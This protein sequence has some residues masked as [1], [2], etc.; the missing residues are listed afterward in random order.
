[1]QKKTSKTSKKAIA[2]D[3]LALLIISILILSTMFLFIQ[4]NKKSTEAISDAELCRNTILSKSQEYLQ[5][6]INKEIE[7]KCPTNYIKLNKKI[8]DSEINKKILDQRDECWYKMGGDSIVSG[9]TDPFKDEKI[10]CV[11]CSV[12]DF[13]PNNREIKGLG[14]DYLKLQSRYITQEQYDAALSRIQSQDKIDG[15]Q[16]YSMLFVQIRDK[17]FIDRNLAAEKSPRELSEMAGG[18]ALAVVGIKVAIAGTAVTMGTIA[19]GGT[20][21]IVGAA[22]GLYG[23]F[24]DQGEPQL[25]AMTTLVKYNKEE[26]QKLGCQELPVSVS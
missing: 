4:Q 18:A 22:I 12:F 5:I 11:V 10:F 14:A 8:S 19:S 16:K 17:D 1:M 9:D 23:Y 2:Y 21:V 26:L 13:G 6:S 7:A 15:N 20:I 24:A 3:I 25:I